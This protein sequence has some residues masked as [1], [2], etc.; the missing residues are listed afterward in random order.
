MSQKIRPQSV[1][2]KNV[3]PDEF[4]QSKNWPSLHHPLRKKIKPV[5]LP[6]TA[7]LDSLP[8]T[9]LTPKDNHNPGFCHQRWIF[10][11]FKI[12]VHTRTYMPNVHIHAHTQYTC[13]HTQYTYTL[14]HIY[15]TVCT[16]LCLGLLI[17]HY[18]SEIYL[19]CLY[20]KNLCLYHSIK[21]F[22]KLPFR[23]YNNFPFKFRC[24]IY[25]EWILCI[26]WRRN[27]YS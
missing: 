17:Q 25:L 27:Q 1:Q 15:N 12:H 5:T 2:I 4:S 26:Q 18:L 23:I 13:T 3:Q 11:V 10:P 19:C 6:L 22:F 8:V 16:S 7:P 21:P 14:T 24:I 20:Q 9:T